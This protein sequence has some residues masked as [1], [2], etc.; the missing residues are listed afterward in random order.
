MTADW[1]WWLLAGVAVWLWV[2]SWFVLFVPRLGPWTIALWPAWVPFWLLVNGGLPFV[3]VARAVRA[4]GSEMPAILDL[5]R[6]RTPPRYR[7]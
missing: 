6:G 3:A 2:A 4:L 7:R 1:P 5:I